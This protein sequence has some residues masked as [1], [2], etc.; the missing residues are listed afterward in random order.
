MQYANYLLYATNSGDEM[1]VYVHSRL[2]PPHDGGERSDLLPCLFNPV[3]GPPY[4]VNRAGIA[5]LV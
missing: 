3:I 2:I 1:E 5:Q 4:S